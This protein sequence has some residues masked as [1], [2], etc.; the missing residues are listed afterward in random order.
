MG[1]VSDAIKNWLGRVLLSGVENT[2]TFLEDTNDNLKEFLDIPTKQAKENE[3]REI[4]KIFRKLI[5]KDGN[6]KSVIKI[7]DNYD[8]TILEKLDMLTTNIEKEL[9]D[10][11]GD[12]ERIRMNLDALKR[13]ADILDDRTSGLLFDLSILKKRRVNIF[14]WF[15]FAVFLLTFA[16]SFWRGPLLYLVYENCHR[17]VHILKEVDRICPAYTILNRVDISNHDDE[18]ETGK[19]GRYASR[20]F[21]LDD[22]HPP[23]GK[24]IFPTSEDEIVNTFKYYTWSDKDDSGRNVTKSYRIYAITG[25]YGAGQDYVA[26]NVVSKLENY[27]TDASSRNMGNKKIPFFVV[28]NNVDDNF[29]EEYGIKHPNRAA[30]IANCIENSDIIDC[31]EDN[32]WSPGYMGSETLLREELDNLVLVVPVKPDMKESDK[33]L[34]KLFGFMEKYKGVRMIL[35]ASNAEWKR[36]ESDT[37]NLK[38]IVFEITPLESTHIEKMYFH[39]FEQ[40]RNREKKEDYEKRYFNKNINVS[41]SVVVNGLKTCTLQS[42]SIQAIMQSAW[43]PGILFAEKAY[44]DLELDSYQK[45]NVGRCFSRKVGAFMETE[46]KGEYNIEK[47]QAASID[48]YLDIHGTAIYFSM[49]NNDMDI[50]SVWEA[51]NK[52]EKREKV[53]VPILKSVYDELF[54]NSSTEKPSK[55]PFKIGDF[56]RIVASHLSLKQSEATDDQQMKADII[57]EHLYM[58]VGENAFIRMKKRY[59]WSDWYLLEGFPLRDLDKKPNGS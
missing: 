57:F 46:P 32:L 14:T 56:E 7:L 36:I 28:I 51:R 20:S 40:E 18:D 33:I 1:E 11:Q 2:K 3:L 35:S 10:A 44:Q 4:A 50:Y 41:T 17:N 58:Q 15:C 27:R 25:K 53:L 8:K 22:S 24:A 6:Q 43:L 19:F 21:K 37:T 42:K 54:S 13:R 34:L 5:D 39:K 31:L 23:E 12:P 47:V 26:A 59:N 30:S 9:S 48:L 55:T 45:D 49:S 52:I 16:V 38:V 29:A